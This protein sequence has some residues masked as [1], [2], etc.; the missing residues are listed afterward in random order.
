[1]IAESQSITL[2]HLGQQAAW[3]TAVQRGIVQGP[4][5]R[6]FWVYRHDE[7]VCE[8]CPQIPGMN[9]NG[10]GLTEAFETPWGPLMTPTAH[11]SCRCSVDYRVG[12]P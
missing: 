7:R 1:M 11:V 5:V 2:A 12:S 8:G 3:Q 6:R 9:P 4:Q 10:V